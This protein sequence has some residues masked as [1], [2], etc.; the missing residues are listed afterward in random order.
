M[1]A[2]SSGVDPLSVIISTVGNIINTA[3]KTIAARY[4]GIVNSNQSAQNYQQGIEL[5]YADVYN[6][7]LKARN[8][9][10]YILGF[11]V[12]IIVLILIFRKR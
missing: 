10:L 8:T 4:D 7:Q 11:I 12:L 5:Q 9:V 3:Q 1:A 6:Q 2:Q